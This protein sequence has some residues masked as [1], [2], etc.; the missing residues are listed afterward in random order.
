M[1]ATEVERKIPETYSNEQMA[2]IL[3]EVCAVAAESKRITGDEFNQTEF[4]AH[5]IELEESGDYSLLSIWGEQ[6]GEWLA[7]RQDMPPEDAPHW[8][9]WITQQ[10]NRLIEGD[11]EAPYGFNSPFSISPDEIAQFR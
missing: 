2:R 4:I 6:V 7:S 9:V 10:W 1:S 11:G 8:E 3:E 5:M